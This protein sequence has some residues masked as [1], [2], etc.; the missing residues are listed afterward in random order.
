MGQ[1]KLYGGNGGNHTFR[2]EI[3]ANERIT[4][5]F[6]YSD[7]FLKGIGLMVKNQNWASWSQE[8]RVIEKK[9]VGRGGVIDVP[10]GKQESISVDRSRKRFIKGAEFYL[11]AH[12]FNKVIDRI[13]FEIISE[14][15]DNVN[16]PNRQKNWT[17][18]YGTSPGVEKGEYFA[19]DGEEIC[20]FYGKWGLKVDSLGFLTRPIPKF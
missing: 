10:Q 3:A 17:K 18:Y 12:W 20:G 15:D 9:S 2:I 6:V 1:S 7:V 5:L 13:K 16:N 11:G 8:F 4:G 19:P 14:E